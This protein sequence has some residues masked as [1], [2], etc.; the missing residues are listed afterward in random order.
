MSKIH[1][2]IKVQDGFVGGDSIQFVVGGFAKPV[3]DSAVLSL[4]QEILRVFVCCFKDENDNVFDD[5][6][7][8]VPYSGEV[9]HKI[10]Q[11]LKNKKERMENIADLE[12]FCNEY[13]LGKI[14]YDALHAYFLPHYDIDVKIEWSEVNREFINVADRLIDLV[15]MCVKRDKTLWVLGV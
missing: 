10:V 7:P 9:L 14:E 8:E 3:P 4:K 2:L 11:N 13:K 6:G 12:E 5:V 1:D 15:S